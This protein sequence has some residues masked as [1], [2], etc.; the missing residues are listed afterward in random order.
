MVD[1]LL[2]VPQKRIHQNL[3][4]ETTVSGLQTMP[5]CISHWKIENASAQH[6]APIPHFSAGASP[7]KASDDTPGMCRARTAPVRIGH[8]ATMWSRSHSRSKLSPRHFG[9]A[10]LIPCGK[11]CSQHPCSSHAEGMPVS[12][13]PT[14][15][16]P[17]DR[18]AID[19]VKIID[20]MRINRV[21]ARFGMRVT[22]PRGSRPSAPCTIAKVVSEDDAAEL[23]PVS[24]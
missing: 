9:T 8:Y 20:G 13:K 1:T 12:G 5:A 14:F 17:S 7:I 2:D 6:P 10:T 4:A 24:V 18:D 11:G 3:I 16:S 15:H 21:A 23:P 19:H 22:Q